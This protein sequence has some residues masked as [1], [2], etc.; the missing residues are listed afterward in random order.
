[1]AFM[2]LRGILIVSLMMVES[3]SHSVFFIRV[4]CSKD[5]SRSDP[6]R[7]SAFLARSILSMDSYSSSMFS[8]VYP[9]TDS[10]PCAFMISSA[11]G[12]VITYCRSFA[13]LCGAYSP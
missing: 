8:K 13:M 6:Y 1:M 10:P 5:S 9:S 2:L 7:F 12:R 4:V 3:L 11:V